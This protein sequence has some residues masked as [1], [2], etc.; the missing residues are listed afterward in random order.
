MTHGKTPKPPRATDRL[1]GLR[2]AHKLPAMIA[3]LALCVGLGIGVVSFTVARGMLLSGVEQNFETALD[4]R[5]GELTAWFEG[6]ERHVAELAYSPTTREAM[7][8]LQSS[9]MF[10]GAESIAA[11]RTGYV[12]D[13]PYPPGEREQLDAAETGTAYDRMHARFHDYFRQVLYGQDYYDIFLI[14][15]DGTVMYTVYKES[16]FTENLVEGELTYSG[17][18]FVFDKAMAVDPGTVVY[19]D[20]SEYAPS[21]DLPAG[22]FATPIAGPNGAPIGILAVQVPPD[23]LQRIM[24]NDVGLGESGQT[25]LI[26]P[27]GRTRNGSRF[28]GEFRTLDPIELTDDE[29]DA[30]TGVEVPVTTRR[31]ENG[32]DYIVS[33]QPFERH[34]ITWVLRAQRELHEAMEPVTALGQRM[35]LIG[36]VALVLVV[37][38]AGWL[39]RTIV[40]A[41]HRLNDSVTGIAG[42]DLATPVPLQHRADEFG[43]M[44]RD[45]DRMRGKLQTA[46]AEAQQRQAEREA[47][48]G[49]VSA[50]EGAIARLRDGDLTVRIHRA[51]PPDYEVL[52]IGLNEA[53]ERVQDAFHQLIECAAA[54]DGRAASIDE[55]AENLSQRATRQ[56]AELEESAAAITELSAS[57]DSTA[58]QAETARRDMERSQEDA[59]E[60]R[61]VMKDAQTAMEQ[62]SE[63]A[64]QV[65]SIVE[66]INSLAFQTNLLALNAGVEAARAGAVGRGFAVVATEVRSLA[67]RSTEAAQQIRKQLDGSAQNV[68]RGAELFEKVGVIYGRITEDI[69]KVGQ[70][71]SGIAVSARDQATTLQT[72][73]T[74]VDTLDHMT[75]ANAQHTSELAEAGSA[76]TEDAANLRRTAGVF[77][78]DARQGTAA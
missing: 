56:A 13:N 54:I 37:A 52:R 26:G 11:L 49:V 25:V 63:S 1:R 12:T 50:L 34:G 20:F 75:Q 55:A 77:K 31:M 41:L 28:D 45:M 43:D 46:D 23:A 73:S 21:A 69:E 2:L 53:L 44:A 51:F 4:G 68:A 6:V 7:N 62:I 38:L 32:R 39:S 8:N 78:T 33:L 57:V 14:G 3:G 24:G 35:L 60:S 17:L 58:G 29:I 66:V 76:L 61:K 27:D 5:T 67:E 71:V 59:R 9:W 72:I 10:M 64:R 40:A 70:T 19:E 22:F 16:D 36:A 74:S 18:G 47:Q 15:L 42:G 48:A 65:G 30:M